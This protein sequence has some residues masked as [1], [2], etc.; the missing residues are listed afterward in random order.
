MNR[1]TTKQKI[2]NLIKRIRKKIPDTVIRTSLSFGFPTEGREEFKELL[3][4][5]KEVKFERLGAFSYSREEGT[6]AFNFPGQL[7]YATKKKRLE[8]LMSL[9]REIVKE[10]NQRFL[11]RDFDVL[12]DEKENGIFVGR[13]EYD[14]HEV[15]GVV[16]INKKGLTIGNFC[17]TKIIDAYEYD[18]LG[19]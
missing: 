17:K 6:P 16:Y 15:D 7:H 3:E 13:S 5:I 10:A 11:G 8:E 18:L 19:V 4:F 12:I 1:K 14:A 2:F 9:Q